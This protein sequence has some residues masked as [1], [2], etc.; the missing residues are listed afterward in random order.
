MLRED[1]AD[2]R[3]TSRDINFVIFKGFARKSIWPTS[4]TNFVVGA[5]FAE[6]RLMELLIPKQLTK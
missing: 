3:Q 4:L 5:A 6:S 1:A 2:R